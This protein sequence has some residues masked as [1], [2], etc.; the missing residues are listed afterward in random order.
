MPV[1]QLLGRAPGGDYPRPAAA[2]LLLSVQAAEDGDPGGLT[3]LVL[4]VV[5]ALSPD[6]VRRDLLGGLAPADA[7]DMGGGIDA[8]VERCAA[9]SLLTWSVTG[10]A[11]IM[12]RLLGRVLCERDQAAG[13]WAGTVTAALEMLEPLLFPEE[14]AWARRDEGAGLAVQVQALWDADAAAGMADPDLTVLLLEARSWAVRQLLAAADLAR[15]ID[16]G[17]RTLTDCVRMLGPDHPVTMT[18]QD[19]LAGAYESAGR[20]GEAIPLFEQALADSVR[21]LGEDHPDTLSSRNNV[22]G[23]YQSA[24]RLGEAIPLYEQNLADSVRVLGEDHPQTLR[25]RNNLAYAY[26]SVGRLGEAIP[27]YEQTLADSVRVLGEDHP[28][29]LRSRNNLAYA[30]QSA[31]RLGRGDPAVRADPR[32]RQ[33]GARRGPPGHPEVAEQPRGRL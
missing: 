19:N 21:V 4:R 28:D 2:A 18:S 3:G 16:A 12:H 11:V 24:G 31:R 30:Y 17:A 9:W 25:S 32:R 1:E 33:A 29:T 10:D 26:Q 23:A 20:L 5:A 8:A 14:Q 7:E 27:L 15:A 6:G 13:Q 22:G